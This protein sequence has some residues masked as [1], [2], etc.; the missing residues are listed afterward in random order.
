MVSLNQ[1]RLARIAALVAGLACA[2][3]GQTVNLDDRL[4]E[5]QQLYI[6]GRYS[7]AQQIFGATLREAEKSQ[8]E[9]GTVARILD[10]LGQTEH[11]L[12]NYTEAENLLN[13]AIAIYQRNAGAD[14]PNAVAV[15]RHLAELYLQELRPA[16]A[17]PLLRRSI[18]VME[19]RANA[20]RADLAV[21]RADLGIALGLE[22]KYG[23]AERELREALEVL[24]TEL[25]PNHP[26]VAAVMLPLSGVLIVEHRYT[27]AIEPAERAWQILQASAP[28]VGQP[29][30]AAALDVL[31]VAYARA[32]RPREGE[33]YLKQAVG[34]AEAIYQADQRQ[35]GYYLRNYAEV[36]K[37]LGRK[38]EGKTLDKRARAILAENDRRI[39][40]SHTVNVNALR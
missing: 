4:E 36:L 22:R 26:K 35:L 13:R 9:S 33:V 38:N 12:G 11:A 39:S 20:D 27:E 34:I 37:Q 5:G 23:E 31:G 28:H 32:G 19:S 18:G 30:I 40:T 6:Q 1:V 16:D 24:E 21:G 2:A 10:L 3:A 7:D 29:D 17:A 15:E 14:A 25:G 8:P